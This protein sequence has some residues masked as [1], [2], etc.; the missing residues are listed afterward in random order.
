MKII[1]KVIETTA[2]VNAQRQLVLDEPLPF[3]GLAKVRIIVFIP[4]EN[5]LDEKEWL[6]AANSGPA[7]DFLK[8]PEEDIYT[9]ADGR[10]FS[11]EG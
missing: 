2:T 10:A 4:K 8:A 5:D 7:F 11:D 1:K 6:R 3:S 9:T